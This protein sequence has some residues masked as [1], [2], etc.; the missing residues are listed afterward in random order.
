M[1]VPTLTRLT[2]HDE[3]RAPRPLISP[4]DN[5][6][7]MS[8]IAR[9]LRRRRRHYRDC[10]FLVAFSLIAFAS[11]SPGVANQSSYTPSPAL[12]QRRQ[13][14]SCQHGH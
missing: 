13:R 8:A 4:D 1:C 12:C 11:T 6:N 9:L 2:D 7:A 10:L 5:S 14:C 3:R